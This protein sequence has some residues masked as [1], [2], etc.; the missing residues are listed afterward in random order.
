[1]AKP[2]VRRRGRLS[3]AG[4]IESDSDIDEPAT[5]KPKH[6]FQPAPND[7]IRFD[8]TNHM[9]AYQ[10]LKRRCRVCGIYVRIICMKCNVYLCINKDNNCFLDYHTSKT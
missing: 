7:E 6:V 3:A 4:N 10:E 8:H 9:P 2:E 1:M 5:F